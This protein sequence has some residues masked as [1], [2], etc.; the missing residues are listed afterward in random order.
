MSFDQLRRREFLGVLGASLAWPLAGRAEQAAAPVIGYLNVGSIGPTSRLLMVFRQGLAEAGY[1]E[2]RNVAIEYRWAEG[3]NDRLPA[4]AAELVRRQVAV[5]V[6]VPNPAALAAKAATETIP[7]V[8]AVADDPVRLGLVASLARPGGNA[9]GFNNFLAELGAKQLG[10]LRQIIPGAA[11]IGLLVNPTNPEAETVTK[12]VVVAAAAIDVQIDLVHARDSREIEAAFATL[13]R[14]GAGA[15]LIASDG[16]F[17]SRRLQLA[18]L[19]MR[20]ALPA[21]HFL[22]EFAEASGLMS[23]GTDLMQANHQLGVYPGRILKGA[24]PADLPVVQSTKFE[25]VINLITAKA[26]G[27]EV[28]A[29]LLAIADEVIE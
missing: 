1:V 14:N 18:T 28:P 26:L 25:L 11:R 7:I 8:F 21:I 10:L 23:Y 15:L 13:T 16:L 20:H 17:F 27:L 2:G 4:M 12:D 5:I 19:A 6:A 24:K 9:T 29:M 3:Q 22:R